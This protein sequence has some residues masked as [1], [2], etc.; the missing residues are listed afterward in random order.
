[1]TYENLNKIYY[2]DNSKWEEEY[3]N[4]FNAPFT[5][6]FDFNIKQYGYNEA[7]PAFYCI[8]PEILKLLDKIHT[9]H[10]TLSHQA[11][12]LPPI[13]AHKIVQTYIIQEIQSSNEIEGVKSSK[14]EIRDALKLSN[15]TNQTKQLR[16]SS[17][18]EKYNEL[19]KRK[20]IKLETSQDIRRLYD[21]FILSEVVNANPNNKPDGI[22]FRAD[23]V[24]ITT[25]TQK[26]LHM[27]TYPE[28]KLIEEMKKALEILHNE[29]YPP[30]IRIAIFHYLFGYIHPFYDGNGRTIRFITSYFISIY[31]PPLVALNISLLINRNQK[32]Y[33]DM[34][35]KTTSYFNRGDLSFFI[36]GF[37]YIIKNSF[38]DV[39]AN[40]TEQLEILTTYREKIHK[41]QTT[42]LTTYALY[43]ILLQATIFSDDG[44]TM[45]DM[46]DSLDKSINTIKSRLTIIPQNHLIID[47]SE[48]IHRYKLNLKAI[49]L[50]ERIEK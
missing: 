26:L 19:A 22:I 15:L 16:F 27:G 47:T 9:L 35:E 46:I 13:A 49:N 4:R 3:N 36:T 31:F 24:E 42:D 41:L 37:L 30:L 32:L 7:Y 25:G 43:E 39:I 45:Q 20:R 28:N 34:F 29:N 14:K 23:N 48:K 44:L 50:I 10:I 12:Y 2:K 33:S 17:V 5:E 38:D 1:M 40:L 11:R 6:H 21:E 8:T 18:I